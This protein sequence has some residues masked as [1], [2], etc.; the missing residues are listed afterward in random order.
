MPLHDMMSNDVS[1]RKQHYTITVESNNKTLVLFEK[2]PVFKRSSK[3]FG[4]RRLPRRRA[5]LPLLASGDFTLEPF[6]FVQDRSS[7]QH[8]D[9]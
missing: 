6:T 7:S 2:G 3:L 4:G 5:Q 9:C 8:D 1:C